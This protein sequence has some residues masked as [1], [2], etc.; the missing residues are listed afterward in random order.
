MQRRKAEPVY[1]GHVPAPVQHLP[2]SDR[3]SRYLAELGISDGEGGSASTR[4]YATS[5]TNNHSAG[6]TIG[7]N[8]S[9]HTEERKHEVIATVRG[10]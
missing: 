6:L 2:T 9:R 5:S 8:S 1:H 4:S 3:D 7:E 10:R